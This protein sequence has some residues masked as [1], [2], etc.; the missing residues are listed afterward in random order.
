MTTPRTVVFVCLHGSAKSVIA[1]AH[2]QRLA[3][4]QRLDVRATAAGLE[5]DAEI[6]AK[7]IDGL[8]EEGLDVRGRRPSRVSPEMLVGAWRVVA[9]GCNL[10]DVPPTVPVD[11]W[12]DVPAVS[13]D[14]HRA[15]DVIVARLTRWLE[16][17]ADPTSFRR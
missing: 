11:R 1:A 9:F 14:F 16:A 6:P 4:Q 12:D 15:R 5:P 2:L 7:V 10:T 8:L 13:E 3:D 17:E